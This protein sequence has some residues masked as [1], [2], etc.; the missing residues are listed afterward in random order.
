MKF[1][2]E[3]LRRAVR[4]F[5]QTAFGYLL[6]NV[7]ASAIGIDYTNGNEIKTLLIGLAVSAVSAGASA[8]MNLEIK[9][10]EE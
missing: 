9:E 3:T 2:K 4:T 1:T 6:T 10:S 7:S 5:L 8:V